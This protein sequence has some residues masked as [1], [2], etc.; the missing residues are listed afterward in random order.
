MADTEKEK[1]AKDGR[2]P[3]QLGD[4]GE[5]LVMFVLGQLKNCT[6]ALIDH[7]GADVIAVD[8][9]TNRKFAISV[10]TRIVLDESKVFYFDEENN[11]RNLK[12]T[13]EILG[14]ESAVAF[15]Y[16]DEQEE[17]TAVR[18]LISPLATLEEMSKDDSCEYVGTYERSGSKGLTIKITEGK[19][20]HYIQEIKNDH[21]IDYTQLNFPAKVLAQ[22]EKR[23]SFL[24]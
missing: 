7:V 2:L 21:R 10:K 23:L 15:V 11:I 9:N 3:K 24:G 14:M 12:E 8:R 5:Q 20:K 19:I 13:S 16:I 18:I 4:F 1:T 22:P 6:V 17:T